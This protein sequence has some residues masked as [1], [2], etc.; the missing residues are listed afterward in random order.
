MRKK[1]KVLTGDEVKMVKTSA[2]AR[3]HNCSE[4][5]VRCVLTGTRA[6]NSAL[7]QM[8]LKDACDIVVIYDRN[9]SK[10]IKSK[11]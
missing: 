4:V 9:T 10:L 7:A 2:L 6:S 1:V 11:K 3:K 5:Y 8:I